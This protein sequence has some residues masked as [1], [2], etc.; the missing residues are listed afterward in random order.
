MSDFPSLLHAARSGDAES[1]GLLMSTQK[2][3]LKLLARVQIGRHLQGKVDASDVVQEAFLQA[4]R[5]FER[6]EGSAEPQFAGWLRSIL[7]HTMANTMRR[8]LGAQSRDPRLEKRLQNDLDKS[9][10]SLGGMLADPRSSPSQ[11]ANRKEQG[12]L[13][14]EAL[15]RLPEHYATVLVLRH[16]ENLTFPTI[17]ERMGRTVDSV[18]KLWLRGLARLRREFGPA[19]A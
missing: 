12:R 6:F 18:E 14:V 10:M 19:E 13:V 8:Y 3:S 17:A 7:A 16:V 9:A 2:P 5:S 11:H 1:L 15:A 4:Q